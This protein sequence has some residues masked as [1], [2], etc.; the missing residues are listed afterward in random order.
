M[1]IMRL[2]KSIS[3]LANAL[4][5]TILG[6]IPKPFAVRLLVAIQ[7]HP[8]IS[9]KWGYFIRPIHYFEALPD[10]STIDPKL[11]VKKR[12]FDQINLT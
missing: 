9:D 8:E 10:F 4:I 3:K 5:I 2:P 7:S 1:E 12:S 6:W 11:I